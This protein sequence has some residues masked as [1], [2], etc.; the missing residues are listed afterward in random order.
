MSAAACSPGMRRRA[1]LTT[2]LLVGTACP[3]GFDEP[4]IRRQC[5][6][7][8]AFS[9]QL[10]GEH[11][12]KQQAWRSAAE[13]FDKACDL[14]PR[15]GCVELG[16]LAEEHHITRGDFAELYARG[17]I[18]G[19]GTGCLYKARSLERSG[20]SRREVSALMKQACQTG[21]TRGCSVDASFDGPHW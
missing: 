13:Y 6:A 4:K 2:L 1:W 20:G 12:A 21:D 8:H 14:S 17:C 9:C 5:L 10:A 19:D 7:G 18:A 16:S 11:F 3:G 15:L